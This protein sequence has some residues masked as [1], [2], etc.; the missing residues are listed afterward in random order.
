MAVAD[1]LEEAA[2]ADSGSGLITIFNRGGW[3]VLQGFLRKRDSELRFF[4]GEVAVK[5]GQKMASNCRRKVRHIFRFIFG[6]PVLG[7][8]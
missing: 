5:D 2:D 3:V 7:T 6:F 4:D 1:L 8:D